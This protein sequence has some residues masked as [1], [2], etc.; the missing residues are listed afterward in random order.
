ML[1]LSIEEAWKQ[2]NSVHMTAALLALFFAGF[3]VL[4]WILTGRL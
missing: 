2:H 4:Y 1:L 3:E